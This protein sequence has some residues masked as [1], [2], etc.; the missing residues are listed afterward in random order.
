MK[1]IAESLATLKALRSR[2]DATSTEDKPFYELKLD[3]RSEAPELYTKLGLESA[4]SLDDIY[5]ILRLHEVRLLEQIDELEQNAA[6]AK[7]DLISELTARAAEKDTIR[8]ATLKV[9]AEIGFDMFPQQETDAVFE[10][11][12]HNQAVREGL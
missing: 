2:L 12:N 5:R 7:A 9:F 3:L 1:P 11:L 8:K 10:W 4:Q 6:G